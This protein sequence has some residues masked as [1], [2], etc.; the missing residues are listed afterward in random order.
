[1]AS[2]QCGPNRRIDAGLRQDRRNSSRQRDAVGI[3]VSIDPFIF[4]V[5]FPV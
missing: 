5:I 4:F 3:P 2:A 1:V